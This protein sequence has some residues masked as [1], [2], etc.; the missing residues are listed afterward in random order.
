M[1]RVIT[2]LGKRII[3]MNLG[4]L[5]VCATEYI[6]Y[7]KVLPA[8]IREQFRNVPL[9]NTAELANPVLVVHDELK[10]VFKHKGGSEAAN[11]I[12]YDAFDNN[13]TMRRAMAL[14][15]I[16]ALS[17]SVG[18]LKER[19]FFLTVTSL[20]LLGNTLFAAH[21]IVSGLNVLKLSSLCLAGNEEVWSNLNEAR[22]AQRLEEVYKTGNKLAK[23]I[24]FWLIVGGMLYNI[25]LLGSALLMSMLSLNWHKKLN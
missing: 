5:L 12:V 13:R 19:S 7:F 20:A 15:M 17:L 2:P 10:F 3:V 11:S 8:R 6:G 4:V 16:S 21:G 24:G 25:P 14:H 9:K 22:Y 18:I 1:N 23:D